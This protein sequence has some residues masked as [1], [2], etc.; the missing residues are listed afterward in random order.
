M[1]RQRIGTALGPWE[2]YR[3]E[4]EQLNNFRLLKDVQAR[5]AT[6]E[7]LSPLEEAEN[8]CLGGFCPQ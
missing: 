3:V 8:L 5:L 2:F 1:R 7:L 4:R 6:V